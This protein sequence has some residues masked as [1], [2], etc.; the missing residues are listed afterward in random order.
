MQSSMC[1]S[2]LTA[3]V[4]REL[5]TDIEGRPFRLCSPCARRLE[6]GALRPL[7]WY[8]L[9][10]IHGPLDAMLHDDFYDEDGIADQN[11][12]PIEQSALFPIPELDAISANPDALLDYALTRWHLDSELIA[13][14][15]AL[16]SD[17]LLLSLTRLEQ[18]RQIPWVAR[19]CYEIA[20]NVLGP[21]AC[22]WIDA[23]W[24]RG[25]RPETVGS[26]LEAVAVCVGTPRALQRA[27]AIIEVSDVRDKSGLASALTKFRSV[28]LLKWMEKNVK[29]P[30]SAGWGWVAG[31]SGFT[32][33]RAQSWLDSGR[34]LS[35]VALDA[36]VNALCPS[37]SNHPPEMHAELGVSPSPN[38]LR[39][40][41]QKYALRDSAPRVTSAV[42][43]IVA[44][45]S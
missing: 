17:S 30:V 39:D 44:S 26:F 20:T 15:R 28:E 33:D 32:W 23:R 42:N 7:E 35:L 31:C 24:E 21:I 3:D 10:A 8:R 4:A 12:I 40:R 18:S 36:I 25:T 2:C 38:D 6:A 41:V 14:F 43:R 34:P 13:A 45:L 11:S 27:L 37:P 1:E 16:P 29:S 22:E 9:A 19:R 5:S